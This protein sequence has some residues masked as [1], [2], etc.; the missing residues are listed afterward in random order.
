MLLAEHRSVPV[1]VDL[2]QIRAPRDQHREPGRQA[3]RHSEPKTLRPVLDRTQRCR[4]PIEV[5]DRVSHL[6]QVENSIEPCI[7]ASIIRLHQAAHRSCHRP[8]HPSSGIRFICPDAGAAGPAVLPRFVG[9][10]RIRIV[11]RGAGAVGVRWRSAGR[12]RGRSE[13]FG[14]PLEISRHAGGSGLALWVRFVG[15]RL[16]RMRCHR[17]CYTR[18][19]RCHACNAPSRAALMPRRLCVSASWAPNASS[20]TASSPVPS[21]RASTSVVWRD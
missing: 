21:E 4:R 11:D 8:D 17:P 14:F 19:R 1:V 18:D 15:P 10:R 9:F 7:H 13:F 2:D 3:D 6:G 5:L 20:P 12:P 16:V